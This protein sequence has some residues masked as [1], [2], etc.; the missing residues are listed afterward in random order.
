[1]II[2]LKYAMIT[3]HKK[4]TTDKLTIKDKT[5]QIMI[6]RSLALIRKASESSGSVIDSLNYIYFRLTT[7][8]TPPPLLW[9]LYCYPPSAAPPPPAAASSPPSSLP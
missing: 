5:K 2:T 8:T 3:P 4:L 7:T 6:N 1:M 9:A